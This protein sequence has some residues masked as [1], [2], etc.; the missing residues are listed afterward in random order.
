[1]GAITRDFG[2]NDHAQCP[3]YPTAPTKAPTK[4]A[5]FTLQQQHRYTGHSCFNFTQQWARDAYTATLATTFSVGTAAVAFSCADEAASGSA[6]AR[7]RQ[8]TS[9]TTA[10]VTYNI[11]VVDEPALAMAQA[12]AA[13]FVGADT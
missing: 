3:H 8:P 9:S 10:V 12:V 7:L 2:T 5:A 1:M 13:E 4:A 11:S 6:T